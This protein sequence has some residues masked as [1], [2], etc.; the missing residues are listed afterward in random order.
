[1]GLVFIFEQKIEDK[2]NVT[3]MRIPW[4]DKRLR[5]EDALVCAGREWYY[6]KGTQ[7]F[8]DF[9][10]KFGL[11]L[12][13][14]SD[15]SFYCR[16]YWFAFR[17]EPWFAKMH[18]GNWSPMLMD[19]TFETLESNGY[20]ELKEPKDLCVVV[21]QI[22][23][24][25]KT[26]EHFGKYNSGKIHSKFAIGHAYEHEIEQVPANWGNYARFFEKKK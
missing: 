21:Y 11:K 2:L 15:F 7:Q 13:E 1:M 26:A 16:C 23:S 14:K 24:S 6:G 8:D 22:E 10:N 25:M 4:T 9:G 5:M 20:I 18:P 3:K 19:K 12:I 17:D